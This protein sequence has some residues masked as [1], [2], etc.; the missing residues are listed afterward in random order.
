MRSAPSET[1]AVR[2]TA[3]RLFTATATTPPSPP[4]WAVMVGIARPPTGHR[5]G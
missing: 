5:A 3:Q 4:A 2:G 1:G